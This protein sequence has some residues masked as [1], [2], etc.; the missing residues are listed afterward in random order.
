MVATTT[1]TLPGVGRDTKPVVFTTPP[2]DKKLYRRITLPNGLLAILIS[3]PE[4]ANQVSGGSESDVD[5][6]EDDSGSQDDENDEVQ[7]RFHH[8]AAPRQATTA[9]SK[10]EN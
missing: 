1:T 2:K 8:P 4:M 5:M 3:D 7:G 9:W 6:S 10:T